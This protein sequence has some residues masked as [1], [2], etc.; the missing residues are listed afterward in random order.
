LFYWVFDFNLKRNEKMS[1]FNFYFPTR[2]VFGQ[3]KFASIGEEVCKLGKR[4]LLV[5]YPSKSLEEPVSQA[6][7]LLA[8]TGVS[9]VIFAE[10][11]ANPTNALINR[12]S[13]ICQRE[14]CDVVIGLGGGSPMDTAKMIALVAPQ[15]LDI[16]NVFETGSSPA[17]SLPMV[18]VPTT[19]GSGS[20]ATYYAVVSHPGLHRKEGFAR[21]QFFPRVSL[22]DPLL[23]LS[24]PPRMTAETGM[25]ALTHAIEAY[26]SKLASPV[27]D[28]YA[29][30]A[31]R[32]VGA[33][34]RKAVANGKDL[35]ARTNMLM[36]NTL[37]GVAITHADTCLAHVIGEAVGAVFNTG[38]GVSVTLAL[39]AVMEYN[40]LANAPKYAGITRLL[41][42]G[43]GLSEEEAAKKS[44]GLVRQLIQDIGL[45]SGLAALGVTESSEVTQLVNRPGMDGS[46]MRPADARAFELLIK[47]SL[48]PAMSYWAAG[49]E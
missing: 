46:N 21:Q 28:L 25:D 15:N 22:I 2:L 42:Y 35:E 10:A 26:T 9:T 17:E 31:I 36:A 24:L 18:A 5:T 20:E 3:G 34:L 4:A 23:T 39:P 47:G 48:S 13:E 11:T 37:A 1:Q 38:H 16:W 29:A 7:A 6:I 45:P 41:G 8:K 30:E 33:N 49:G 43:S 19:A 12:G 14:Q 32:L 44:P 27:S 40:C